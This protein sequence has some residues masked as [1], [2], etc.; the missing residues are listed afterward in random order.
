MSIQMVD[1]LQ[2]S[3]E[4]LGARRVELLAELAEVEGLLHANMRRM[5]DEG[6]TQV[7]VM[8]A[9][10][11]RSIDAVRKIVDPAVKE[12]AAAARKAKRAHRAV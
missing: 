9:S 7:E 3:V 10:Q 5:R 11:Y 6:A 8:T 4:H 2:S 1:S 12:A